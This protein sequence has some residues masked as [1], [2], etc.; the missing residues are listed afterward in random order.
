MRVRKMSAQV[1]V[2]GPERALFS[3]FDLVE[4]VTRDRVIEIGLGV[5]QWIEIQHVTSGGLLIKRI[6]I[7]NVT[8]KFKDLRPIFCLVSH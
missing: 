7:Q 1:Q 6:K 4:L 2:F 5:I 8:S 3:V